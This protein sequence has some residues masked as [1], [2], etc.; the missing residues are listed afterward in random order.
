M[1]ECRTK[2]QFKGLKGNLM[3]LKEHEERQALDNCIIQ[4]LKTDPL[5]ISCF[6]LIMWN[7]QA[8]CTRG[9]ILA[10]CIASFLKVTSRGPGAVRS[11]HA[12]Q[13]VQDFGIQQCAWKLLC[14][15]NCALRIWILLGNWCLYNVVC[16][17][18]EKMFWKW[19]I[20]ALAGQYCLWP[21]YSRQVLNMAIL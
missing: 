3:G 8:K 4:L 21:A 14:K 18:K 15:S 5:E 13:K 2:R 1:N 20:R 6:K 9:Y 10:P 19:W 17:R 16:L 11:Q 12:I 7:N